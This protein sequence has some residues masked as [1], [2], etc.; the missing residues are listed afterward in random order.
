M[1]LNDEEAIHFSVERFIR[2]TKSFVFLMSPS[3]EYDVLIIKTL[4]S[5][6]KR[7]VNF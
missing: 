3:T 5:S 1:C 6:Q 2:N 7:L 4:L